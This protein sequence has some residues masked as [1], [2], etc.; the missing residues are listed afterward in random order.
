MSLKESIAG[1]LTAARTRTLA[2]LELVPRDTWSLR[3]HDFYSPIGWHFGHIARTEEYWVS[4]ALGLAPHDERADFLFADSPDNPKEARVHLP[5]IESVLGYMRNVRE[6]SLSLLYGADIETDSPLLADGFAWEFAYQHE[7]QHQETILELL[8]LIHQH[9]STPPKEARVAWRHSTGR[10]LSVERTAFCMGTDE[11]HAYDNEKEPHRVTVEA[12]TTTDRPITAFEW[13]EFV[14]DGGYRLEALWSPEG[15]AWRRR[16][17]AQRPE[18]WFEVD[19][20]RFT[21]C[22]EGSRAVN[23]DEP[24]GSI[25]WW[26]AEAFARW[27]GKRLL[28]EHEREL[29][30]TLY[31]VNGRVWEW[32]SSDFAPY[33]GFAAF[34]YDGYSKVHMDGAHKVCRGGSWASAEPVLRPTFRNWYAPGYRQGFLG[35]RLAELSSYQLL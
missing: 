25:N 22:P 23:P 7:C 2:L 34:P 14:T 21:Y 3:V 17:D 31:P 26:E 30:A 11:R 28:T 24:A 15:W 5:P 6:R 29:L 33:P 18:Y 9:L 19:G 16:L 1:R 12:F 32:T 8:C 35:V 4:R 13:S 27:S 10:A 20:A